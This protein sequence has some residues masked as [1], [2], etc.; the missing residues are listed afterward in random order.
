MPASEIKLLIINESIV[1]CSN[2]MILLSP[3]SRNITACSKYARGLA[4]LENAIKRQQPFDFVFL[5]YPP[6][7]HQEIDTAVQALALAL[8]SCGPK[9]TVILSGEK[10]P[11]RFSSMGADGDLLLAKPITREKLEGVLKIAGQDLPK[12]S[13]WQYMECGREPGG[14]NA[15]GLG[16]CP[17]AVEQAAEGIH[18]GSCGGRVCWAISGTLCGG[19]VQGTFACKIESCLTCD[20]YRLVELE[21]YTRLESIDSILSRI[22]R[23][24]E[25]LGTRSD[26]DGAD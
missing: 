25:W 6:G 21:E 13:C 12:L 9:R 24:R 2:L 14:R 17:A 20:F 5:S 8:Q 22:R 18:G 3:L 4:A 10:L 11:P 15:G 23:K 7:H 16:V 1:E 19:K 26:K